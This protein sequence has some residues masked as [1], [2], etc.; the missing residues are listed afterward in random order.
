MEKA[1][2]NYTLSPKA[3]NDISIIFDYTVKEFNFDKAVIYTRDFK[4]VFNSLLFI[5]TL[6]LDRSEIKK[7]LYSISK[8]KHVIFYRVFKDSIRIV[9]VLHGSRDLPKHF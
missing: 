9:R 5:P 8:N 3:K 7:G 4:E 1:K 2:K 6:G